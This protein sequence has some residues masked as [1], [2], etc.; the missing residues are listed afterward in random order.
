MK[1]NFRFI[2]IANLRRV[3]R[4]QTSTTTTTTTTATMTTATT[5][6]ITVELELFDADSPTNNIKM[7]DQDVHLGIWLRQRSCYCQFHS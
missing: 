6:P 1:D 3:R 4:M 5:T 2:V 7:L